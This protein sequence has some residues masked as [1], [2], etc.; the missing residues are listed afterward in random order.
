MP[1]IFSKNSNLNDS[2]FGKSAEPIMLLIE[3]KAEAFE[4]KSAIKDL[5]KVKKSKHFAEKIASM[6]SMDSAV[7]VGEGGAYPKASMEEGYS[8]VIE[9]ETWKNQFVITREM[10]DDGVAL[11]ESK[12]T[13]FTESFYR[14]REEFAGNL[15]A[16]AIGGSAMPYGSSAFADSAKSAD[17]QFQFA[18]SHPSKVKGGA[19]SNKFSDA[20]TADALAKLESRMQNFKDDNGKLLSVSP[21]TILIPNDWSVKKA[22]FAAIGADKDPA[23]A[24]NGFNY[25]FGRWNVIVWPYL[26][27]VIGSNN[28]PWILLDSNYNKTYAGA[29]WVDRVPLE[30]RTWVDDNTDN[31]V[32]NGYARFSAGFNDWRFAAVGGCTGGTEL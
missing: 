11:D 18:T 16:A 25:Q 1:V 19:Q 13:G 5:F 17:G 22:V 7:P 8:K 21:D 14:A 30:V 9:P 3:R 6:T 32:W 28:V 24:N 27:S 2:I 23:T 26:N 15:F 29:V 20:F 4:Q 31:N 12:P 10:M